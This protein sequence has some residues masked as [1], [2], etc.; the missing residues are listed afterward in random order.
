MQMNY[1]KTVL[2]IFSIVYFSLVITFSYEKAI[3][4]SNLEFYNNYSA[5]NI[6]FFK[7]KQ[8]NILSKF[9]VKNGLSNTSKYIQVNGY[10]NYESLLESFSKILISMYAE[11]IINKNETQKII[12]RVMEVFEKESENPIAIRNNIGA[13]IEELF[14]ID[15]N[16]NSRLKN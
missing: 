10:K 2:F 1:L 7:K 6:I 5:W 12:I 4:L 3:D 8:N 15:K 16:V 14:E 13:L 11:N 9:I